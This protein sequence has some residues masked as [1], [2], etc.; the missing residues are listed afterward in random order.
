MGVF[1]ECAS[2]TSP[3]GGILRN[4]LFLLLRREVFYGMRFFEFSGGG[5]GILRNALLGLLQRGVFYGMRFFDFT[6]GVLRV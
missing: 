4:A 6:E 1:S 2:L 3:G 5:E